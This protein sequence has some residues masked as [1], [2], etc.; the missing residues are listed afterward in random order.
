MKKLNLRF[1]IFCFV[2]FTVIVSH[3]TLQS[4]NVENKEKPSQT[5]CKDTNGTIVGYGANC[6]CG[7]SKCVSNP[8]PKAPP[9]E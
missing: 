6:V 3:Y 1:L 4:Q 5:I 7:Q 9:I 8:C 2:A